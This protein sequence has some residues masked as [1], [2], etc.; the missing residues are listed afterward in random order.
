[1]S[2]RRRIRTSRANG[3]RSRGPITPE[4]KRRSAANATRH[5]LLA[6]CVVLENESA[7]SFEALLAHHLK[8]FGP[9]DEVEFGMLEEM[10]AAYW[11]MR[12]AWAIETRLIEDGMQTQTAADAIGRLTAAYSEL[13]TGPQLALLQRYESRLHRMYHRG[14]TNLLLLR[15]DRLS[16]AQIGETQID[17]TNPVP[18]PD[19]SEL[20]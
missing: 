14:L 17:Q 16:E 6:K 20:A 8:R 12:R 11:R 19:S 18:F 5:G 3:A 1:M 4:G 9:L 7:E 10:A 2:S 15:E 13:A